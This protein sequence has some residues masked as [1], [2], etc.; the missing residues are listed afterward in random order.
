MSWRGRAIGIACCAAATA[1]AHGFGQRYDLPLPLSLYICGAALTVIVSCVMIAIFVRAA[2]KDHPFPHVDLLKYRP[3]RLL[4]SPAAIAGIRLAAVAFYLLLLAAGFLGNPSPF[5]NIVPIAV[6]ALWWV[7]LAYFSALIGDLWRIANPLETLFAAAERAYGRLRGGRPLSLDLAIPP[8]VEA[9]PAV[10]LY[11]AFLWMEM[12]WEGSDSPLQV[13]AAIAAYSALTWTGM[14]LFGRE[15]WIERGEVFTRV[16]GVFARFSPTRI[17][18]SGRQVAQWE[19]RPYAVGLLNRDPVD[20]STMVLV[21][22]ILA[23]VSFDGFMETPAWAGIVEMLSGAE[24]PARWPRSL[25]LLLAPLVFLAVYLAF[26]RL[27]AVSGSP[28][29]QRAKIRGT[30]RRVAGLFV[31]TLVPIAIAYQVAHYLSFLATAG[32][33][34]I[35]L[36]SDPLGR[37]WNLFGTVNHFVRAGIVDAR[38]VWIISVAAIVSGHVAA[39]YLGHLLAMREFPERRAALR[40]QGPMLLLMVGY[41]MLSLWIIAQ[42]IVTSR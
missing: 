9:W 26:C 23:A 10:A 38:L 7:G 36:A 39:L 32:E 29:G 41:T 22:L 37:G 24:E 21:V 40:S 5:R 12:V 17:R 14:W 2:P 30:T 8:Q 3:L 33:Y 19:L 42:P 35:V 18:L 31:L 1:Q 15:A 11:L 4:A 20:A 27:I 16:F 25:G 28:R 34:L 6:W 13:A